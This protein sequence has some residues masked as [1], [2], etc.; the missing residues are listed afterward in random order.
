MYLSANN[1]LNGSLAILGAGIIYTTYQAA[2]NGI[3]KF[4]ID[5]IFYTIGAIPAIVGIIRFFLSKKG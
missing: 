1:K 4:P 5:C 2:S 3:I